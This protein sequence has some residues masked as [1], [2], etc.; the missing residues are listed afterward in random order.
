MIS[1][2]IDCVS[3]RAFQLF[4]AGPVWTKYSLD[5]TDFATAASQNQIVLGNLPAETVIHAVVIKH[6][7][8]FGG[9]AIA[10]YVLKVGTVATPGKF[11]SPFDVFQA[12]GDTIGQVSTGGWCE[13][14]ANAYDV[15][16]TADSTGDTLDNATTGA[17]DVWLYT[18][19]L[20]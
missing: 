16:I 7:A 14:Y 12:P 19:N 10:S 4:G 1:I 15:Y 9:G 6:S 2:S 17:V 5:Y 8:A 18:S 3:P 20:S 11:A 13:D